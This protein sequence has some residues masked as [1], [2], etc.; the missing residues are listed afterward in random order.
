MVQF[1][2]FI[3]WIISPYW[4]FSSPPAFLVY[5]I[6]DITEPGWIGICGS[7]VDGTQVISS[8]YYFDQVTYNGRHLN[9]HS[10]EQVASYGFD[11]FDLDADK[12]SVIE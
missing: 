2:Q 12:R 5:R 1:N 6:S 8:L 3:S 9:P 11:R 7:D 10:K 4:Y